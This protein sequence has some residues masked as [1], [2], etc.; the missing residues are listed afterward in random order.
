M[1]PQPSLFGLTGGVSNP[2][3]D[4]ISPSGSEQPPQVQPGI[5]SAAAAGGLHQ[6]QIHQQN[7]RSQSPALKWYK[8]STSSE[9][10][11]DVTT[12]SKCQIVVGY[13][14]NNKLLHVVV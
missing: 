11:A 12:K 10:A 8:R 9:A 5:G 7:F 3:L 14:D 1:S 6:Q 4:S 2:R 13:D